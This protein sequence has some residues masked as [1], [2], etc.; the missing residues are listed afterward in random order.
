MGSIF[1]KIKRDF[2]MSSQLSVI[3]NNQIYIENCKN[4]LECNENLVRILSNNFEIEVWGSELFVT[5]YSSNAV[6]V[7]GKITS[8][9]INER[10]KHK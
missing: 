1:E 9:S 6:L 3:D 2:Y 7:K 4:I 10:R 8:I 5:N